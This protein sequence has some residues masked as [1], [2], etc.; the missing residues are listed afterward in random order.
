MTVDRQD[1][2]QSIQVRLTKRE[3]EV[4][5]LVL[6]GKSSKE[7]AD[8]LFCSKR[9]IDFHLAR[10]YEK[11]DVSNRVQAIRRATMLGL[12]EIDSARANPA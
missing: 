2:A 9:T 8:E 11:L 4:L 7:V 12:V 5:S 6:E 1:G 3:V 10:I